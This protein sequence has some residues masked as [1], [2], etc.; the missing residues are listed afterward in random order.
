MSKNGVLLLNISPKAD[1][2]IPADQ[3]AALL[4][5]G[6]WLYTHG[7]SIYGTRS[8]YTYGEGPTKEPEGSFDNHQQFAKIKY[9]NK[10]IRFTTKGNVI[11]ATLLGKP[12][13][14]QPILFESFAKAQLKK[15]LKITSITMLS[16][17]DKLKWGLADTGLTVTAP[18]QVPDEMATVF[19]ITTQQ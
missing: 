2:T 7:E 5:I 17:K 19:K 11:Y 18:T 16:S 3:K 14:G 9:S 10:D 12:T 1:G 4:A 8:W 13:P 6:K 15:P